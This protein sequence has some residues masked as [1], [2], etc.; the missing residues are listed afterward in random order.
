MTVPMSNSDAATPSMSELLESS[1]SAVNY[2]AGTWIYKKGDSG[3]YAYLIK[4]GYV[5]IHSD[6]NGQ[7][8]SLEL[9]GPWSSS[10]EKHEPPLRSPHMIRVFIQSHAISYAMRSIEQVRLPNKS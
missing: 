9:L 8:N 7:S 2:Q 5:E 1:T 4:S 3:T 6:I 10:M